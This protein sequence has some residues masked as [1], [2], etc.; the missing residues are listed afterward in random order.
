M[1]GRENGRGASET[2]R[3]S[4]RWASKIHQTANSL[5]PTLASAPSFFAST[6]GSDGKQPLN[7]LGWLAPSDPQ[8][9]FAVSVLQRRVSVW[10]GRTGYGLTESSTAEAA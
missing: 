6:A 10:R 1:T 2:L 8:E 9:T 4:D 3:G 7:S 5:K